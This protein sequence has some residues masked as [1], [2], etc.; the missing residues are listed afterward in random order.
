MNQIKEI[1]ESLVFNVFE[2][3]VPNYPG[4]GGG[5]GDFRDVFFFM[6][7]FLFVCR[8]IQQSNNR[9]WLAAV[10]VGRFAAGLGQT[11]S[12]IPVHYCPMSGRLE[13]DGRVFKKSSR[14]VVG[15]H[16]IQFFRK[17]TTDRFHRI[18]AR[19]QFTVSVCREYRQ[20][21]RMQF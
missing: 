20:A 8:I 15:D 13:T 3:F 12:F 21:R 5:W 11:E 7:V 6:T 9:K 17:S 2:S 10:P 18:S 14:R 4:G 19:R 1:N 16:S